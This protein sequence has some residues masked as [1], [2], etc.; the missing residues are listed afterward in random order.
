M[1]RGS[2]NVRIKSNV[3]GA[4]HLGRRQCLQRPM[5]GT[6]G[7]IRDSILVRRSMMNDV[8]RPITV[9][10]CPIIIVQYSR[11][12]DHQRSII[13]T[14]TPTRQD[15][16]MPLATAKEIIAIQHVSARSLEIHT[17][18]IQFESVLGEDV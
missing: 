2:N 6:G 7:V 3:N 12:D 13:Q 15:Y 5:E 10:V 8:S 16:D 1:V 9:S 11:L 14:L 17:V 4:A 18:T